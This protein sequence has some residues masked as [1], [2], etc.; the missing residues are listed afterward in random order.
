MEYAL[1]ALAPIFIGFILWERRRL[2]KRGTPYSLREL[3]CNLVLAGLYQLTEILSMLLILPLALWLYEQ[4]PM[5]Q[6]ITWWSIALLVLMQDFLYYWFHRASH[7]IRW[8][9]AAHVVHHSSENFN[10]ST[11]MRQSLMYPL[12]G[13]WVFWLPLVLLGFHPAHVFFV[14]AIN[15]AYQFFVHTRMVRSLGPLEWLFNTPAHHSVHHARNPEY[16]DRNFAGVLIIWDRL[17]G[18]FVKERQ[19]TPIDYGIP[20]PID[21]NN[22]LVATFHEWQDLWRDAT[23]SGKPMSV[24][25]RHLYKPPAWQPG[26]EPENEASAGINEP[27]LR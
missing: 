14:A 23:A 16:I 1:M 20:H 8:M 10:F 5:Q 2:A 26:E 18:T 15:L 19:D 6:Q 4:A 13:I 25:L 17:F 24:R 3:V 22:P 12:A 7:S 21:A 11:A 9:W 27:P